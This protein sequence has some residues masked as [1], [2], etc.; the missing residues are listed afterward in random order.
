MQDSPRT[1]VILMIMIGHFLDYSI[2]DVMECQS[3]NV[4]HSANI[5]LQGGRWLS[6]ATIWGR[7]H[8]GEGGNSIW[9]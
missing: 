5:S 3:S 4:K 8:L 9:A 6:R 2:S 7:M 1:V